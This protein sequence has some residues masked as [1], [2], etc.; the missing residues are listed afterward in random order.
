MSNLSY[1]LFERGR[2]H[3]LSFPEFYDSPLWEKEIQFKN[4]LLGR[5]PFLYIEAKNWGI[6]LQW[7]FGPYLQIRV[8]KHSLRIN[9]GVVH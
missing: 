8:T 3:S 7:D 5:F 4:S 9:W 6:F 1:L 2:I